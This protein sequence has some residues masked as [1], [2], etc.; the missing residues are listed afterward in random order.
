VNINSKLVVTC[1]MLRSTMQMARSGMGYIMS[2]KACWYTSSNILKQ[3]R[4]SDLLGLADERADNS[5]HVE[6]RVKGFGAMAIPLVH[7]WKEM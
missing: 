1:V 3:I 6:G 4:R 7:P 5:I 2:V